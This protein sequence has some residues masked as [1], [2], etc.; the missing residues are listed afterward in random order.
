MRRRRRTRKRETKGPKPQKNVVDTSSLR[1]K[2]CF[3]PIL[4]SNTI[5][6]VSFFFV[7]IILLNLLRRA[8]GMDSSAMSRATLC[9]PG[10]KGSFQSGSSSM[11]T[12]P[13]S[14]EICGLGSWVWGSR[15]K[16]HW[17]RCGSLWT[18]TI[19][20]L[21]RVRHWRFRSKARG[22]KRGK[23]ESEDQRVQDFCANS[24]GYSVRMHNLQH[25]F[26]PVF[27][28]VSV[29]IDDTKLPPPPPP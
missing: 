2:M 4:W 9:L 3:H 11:C 12:T 18:M 24:S 6:P 21:P 25:T 1:D 27:S 13:E 15:F 8:Y 29:A 5:S 7:L 16:V 23:R 28:E 26:T 22:C 17:K 19:G 14:C 20:G 10:H